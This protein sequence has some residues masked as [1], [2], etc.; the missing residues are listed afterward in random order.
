MKCPICE[1][2]LKRFSFDNPKELLFQCVDCNFNIKIQKF[3]IRFY[4][5]NYK[6]IFNYITDEFIYK[7]Y[8]EDFS[9]QKKVEIEKLKLNELFEKLKYF[10]NFYRQKN[11]KRKISYYPVFY[12]KCYK[13][14]EVR[15]FKCFYNSAKYLQLAE[16][17]DCYKKRYSY[18]YHDYNNLIHRKYCKIR[19]R[20]KNIFKTNL[21]F[22]EVEFKKWLENNNY[23][24]I[25]DIMMDNLG[26]NA[27]DICV[28]RK[29]K[30]IEYVFGNMII[31]F[32]KDY[33]KKLNSIHIK[34][35]KKPVVQL[36]DGKIVK[37]WPSATDA[38]VIPKVFQSNINKVCN[39]K[40]KS[41]AGYEWKYL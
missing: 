18:D 24:K 12:K 11:K 3:I 33:F 27:Y 38:E 36:K 2:Q 20:Q 41:H 13:C 1:K 4:L 22:N 34:R 7:M 32:R 35:K 14:G 8:V 40:L 21:Q 29:N 23:K 31:M 28:I 26:N 10:I 9:E 5:T 25:Y 30:K 17:K 6:F 19:N 15:L 39:G 37:I 16:C